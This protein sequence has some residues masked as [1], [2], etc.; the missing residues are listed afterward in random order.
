MPEEFKIRTDLLAPEFVK[1]L[2][3]SGYDPT[4]LF[5]IIPE[6]LKDVFKLDSPKIFE[7][8]IKWDN[9]ADP[10]KFFGHWRAKDT[11]DERTKVW[12]IIKMQG[13]VHT[14]DKRGSVT[15]WIYGYMEATYPWE[16]LLDKIVTRIN[17]W[18]FYAEQ[19]RKYLEEARLRLNIL[20]SEV[21]KVFEIMQKES[22]V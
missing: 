4:R 2:E 5:A 13:E 15:I 20:E 7:D 17:L 16:N 3:F 9:A 19:K 8:E 1:T 21:R 6:L 18:F 14:Q 11:K 22:K 12:P 10:I